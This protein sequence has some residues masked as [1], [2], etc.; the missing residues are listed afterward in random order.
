MATES[1]GLEAAL[2]IATGSVP[3][4]ADGPHTSGGRSPLHE[5]VLRRQYAEAASLLAHGADWTARNDE[6]KAPLEIGFA[7]LDTLHRIRQEYQRLPLAVGG[8]R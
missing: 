4:I 5:A 1:L 3:A 8:I 7:D 2:R 6:G